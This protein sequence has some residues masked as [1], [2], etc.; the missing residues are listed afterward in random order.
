M[1]R[2]FNVR[3][4]YTHGTKPYSAYFTSS[5][6]R[7]LDFYEFRDGKFY[8]PKQRVD[9]IRQ[10]GGDAVSNKAYELSVASDGKRTLIVT[11]ETL[12]RNGGASFTRKVFSESLGY[13]C[14]LSERVGA[15]GKG[16]EKRTVQDFV[17]D[18]A[19]GAFLPRY[20]R[21]IRN[22]IEEDGTV[23]PNSVT[24]IEV[25]ELVVQDEVLGELFSEAALPL[26]K[27]DRIHDV[28]TR[29]VWSVQGD[30]TWQEVTRK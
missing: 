16:V 5:H 2:D 3:G 10:R 1:G 21:E 27:G 6:L 23:S 7:S 24:E 19:S 12:R 4:F 26:R 8:T 17:F 25:L 22:S 15:D 11:T 28:S 9:E 20:A 18:A 13:N 29:E 30:G 14:V